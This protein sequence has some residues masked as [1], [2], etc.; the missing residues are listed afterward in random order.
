LANFWLVAKQVIV[1]FALIGIGAVC[2]KTKLVDTTS[3]KGLINVLILIVTPAVM[4]ECFQRP[5]DAA[6]LGQL[7]IAFVAAALMHVLLIVVSHLASRG[8]DRT[9]PVA[10]LSTVFS[11]A[12]FMGIPLEY[13]IL[14][15]EGV[16]YG[17]VY[18]AMFN[19]FIWSWGLMT[20]RGTLA[21]E[22]RTDG[23]RRFLNPV[24]VNPGTIGLLLGLLVFLCS[25]QLPPLL[26]QP[27]KM[28]ADLNTPLA[29]IVI[30]YYLG[31]ADLGKVVCSRPAHVACLIRL[32]VSPL[33][34]I[35][36]FYPFRT[37]LDRSMMLA[38]VIAAS[39]PVGAM[40]AM[41]AAKYERD[42]DLAVGLV[43]GTTIMS[44][45]TMPVVIALAM[46]C[47]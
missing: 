45:V 22:R 17:V 25:L 32:I 24:F 39:A 34:M 37:M 38:M 40:V 46:T 35:A 7:G 42:V 44:I 2:R 3:I 16:F 20:M 1:L 27:V 31:G 5:F 21:D 4:V 30:G 33:A 12:G 11:N 19:L 13:A 23:W 9:R 28:L 29:M 43:S 26:Q 18:V 36:I 41:F 47:L 8:D 10:A 14:G 15:A 6:M